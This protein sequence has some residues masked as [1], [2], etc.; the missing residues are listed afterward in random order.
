MPRQ[1]LREYVKLLI[2]T[3][4]KDPGAG[5]IVVRKFLGEDQHR[6]LGLLY[7]NKKGTWDI[8]KGV[9]EPGEKPLSTAVRETEEEASIT[10]LNFRW[11]QQPI[12]ISH[13]SL[14][15]AETNQDPQIVANPHTG[16][17]EH[18]GAEWL[19]WKEMLSSC[20]TYLSPGIVEAMRIVETSNAILT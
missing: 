19:T 14:Y 3:D 1:M 9:I 13:L 7:P 5:I 17:I 8:P 6:V 11:G 16:I 4:K 2:Q 10:G 18:Q 20:Y 15:I 12:L